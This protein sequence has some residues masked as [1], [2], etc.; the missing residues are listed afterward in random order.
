MKKNKKSKKM[1]IEDLSVKMAEGFLSSDKKLE[2]FGKKFDAKLENLA[3]MTAKGFENVDKRFEVVDERFESIDERFESIDKRFESMDKRFDGVDAR[4]DKV[5][6][7]LFS[8]EDNQLD[9]K[10]RFEVFEKHH[11]PAVEN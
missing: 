7:R 2:S 10:L 9:L 4:L 5:E 11:I 3:M 1:T 6:S 8:V